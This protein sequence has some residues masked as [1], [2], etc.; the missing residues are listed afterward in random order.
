MLR[1]AWHVRFRQEA[2]LGLLMA[3][4]AFGLVTRSKLHEWLVMASFLA[5]LSLGSRTLAVKPTCMDKTKTRVV[6]VVS[7]ARTV[8]RVNSMLAKGA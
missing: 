8:L 5:L 6:R 2:V 4:G 1:I 3:A 7:S